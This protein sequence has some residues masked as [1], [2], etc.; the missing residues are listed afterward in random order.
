[1]K[2]YN[3]PCI[4]NDFYTDIINLS[5]WKTMTHLS[6]LLNTMADDNLV[7]QGARASATMVLTQFWSI[8]ASASDG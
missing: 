7:R 6:H 8:L 1:M 5:S 3:Y 4:L 2:S